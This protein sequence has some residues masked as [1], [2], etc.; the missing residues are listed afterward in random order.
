MRVKQEELA[1]IKQQEDKDFRQDIKEDNVDES[2]RAED[3]EMME[4]YRQ[5]NYRPFIDPVI[6]PYHYPFL[7]FYNYPPFKK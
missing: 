5:A 1:F 3:Q 7:P 2:Y 4:Y 6:P